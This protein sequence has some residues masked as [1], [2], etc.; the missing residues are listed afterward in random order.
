MDG[1]INESMSNDQNLMNKWKT[2][3]EVS[4]GSRKELRRWINIKRGFLQGDSYSPMGFCLTEVPITML[5]DGTKG[6]RMGPPRN[7]DVKRTHNLFID[8]LKVYQESHEKMLMVN[9]TIVQAS[10]DTGACYGVKKCTEIVFKQGKMVKGEGL[11]I[12]QETMKALDPEHKQ[13]YKFLGCEQAEIDMD[14]VMLRVTTEI[15]K[16]IKEPV[17]QELYDK[18]L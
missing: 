6:Y 16:R 7:R 15:E 17:K 11:N 10:V 1:D 2:R 8:D 9:D 4:N 13:I 12:S 5:L 3:L 14:R 18:N